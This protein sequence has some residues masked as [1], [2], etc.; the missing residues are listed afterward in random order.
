ML[1]NIFTYVNK[2]NVKQQRYISDLHSL[3][4]DWLTTLLSC[5]TVFKSWENVFPMFYPVHN[6]I[7]TEATHI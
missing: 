1:S 7:S 3:S 6:V 5:V 2:T 4:S